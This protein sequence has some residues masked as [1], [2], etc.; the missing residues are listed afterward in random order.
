MNA[1]WPMVAVRRTATTRT[2][3][4]TAHAQLGLSYTTNCSVEVGKQANKTTRKKREKSERI[5]FLRIQIRLQIVKDSSHRGESTFLL[6]LRS[7]S[8]TILS[9]ISKLC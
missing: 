1:V 2:E 5:F 9:V 4:I 3:V 8:Q 6:L 7:G